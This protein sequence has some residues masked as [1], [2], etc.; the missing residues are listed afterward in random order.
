MGKEYPA[1]EAA[2]WGQEI[3]GISRKF[4]GDVRNALTEAAGRGFSVLPGHVQELIVATG[5]EAKLKATEANAKIFQG[6]TERR[7]KEEEVDQKIVLGLAR[8]DLELLKAD[9]DNAHELAKALQDMTLD[10]QRGAIQ[11]LQSDVDKRQAYIIEERAL[12]EREVTYWKR[13]AIEAEGI[14]LDA[15]VQ[16]AR[17]RVKTAEEK[18]RII[19]YLYQVIAAEQIV[20]AAEL[21]RA[22]V[23]ETVIAKQEEVAAIKKTMIP[24]Y[25][26]KAEARLR[27]AEAIK[28]EAEYRKQIEELGYRRIDLKRAQ[29][30]AD[31]QVRQAE[32]VYEEA[33]YAYF[34]AERTTELARAEARTML[35]EFEALIKEKLIKMKKALDKEERRFRLD[36][37]L[38]WEKYGWGQD[39][40]YTEMQRA[41]LMADFMEK[42]NNITDAA[43]AKADATMAGQRQIHVRQSW[44]HMHQY[45]SKG[46]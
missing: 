25:E 34:K 38:F 41:R 5:L 37:R 30:D 26:D 14:A 3:D 46:S 29:E 20:I 18:L 45:I 40:S 11:R 35:L 42:I 17:E 32:E 9:Y 43:A 44:Q 2:Q 10:E 12:I 21:R 23:L 36:Q 7:L 13:Q 28:E 33:R 22:E 19:E 6:M 39:F 27:D 4:R 16:L 31:H 8:L 15:E 24:L 1:D